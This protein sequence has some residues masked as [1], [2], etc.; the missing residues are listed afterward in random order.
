ME[1]DSK[2]KVEIALNP[3]FIMYKGWRSILTTN[4]FITWIIFSIIIFVLYY[5][6]NSK[7]DLFPISD[8]IAPAITGLSFTLALIVATNKI[9]T[10]DQLVDIYKYDDGGTKEEGYL[11]YE[12]IAPY[13]FTSTVWLIVAI[14]ALLAKLFVFD[15][16]NAENDIIKLLYSSIVLLGLIS[17]WSL[18]TMH[19]QDLAMEAQREINKEIKENNENEEESS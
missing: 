13:I 12:T 5:C 17:L 7:I 8:F 6:Q 15:F 10:K 16:S 2:N 3:F 11:F 18:L 4:L 9:F 19:I 1:K 14:G